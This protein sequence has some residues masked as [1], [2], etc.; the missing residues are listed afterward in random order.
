MENIKSR[1]QQ[2]DRDILNAVMPLISNFNLETGLSIVNLTV[3]FGEV[4]V[5]G[6]IDERFRPIGVNIDIIL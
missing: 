6:D 3:E 1:K 2:L 5:F 4:T